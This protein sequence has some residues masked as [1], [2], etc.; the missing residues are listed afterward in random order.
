MAGNG[1]TPTEKGAHLRGR[2]TSNTKP[3]VDLRRAVH[4]LGLRFRLHQRVVG[5]CTPDFVLPRWRL[6][7]FVDG[8]FW[9]GCPKHSPAEFR[10]PNAEKWRE[11]IDTNRVRDLRNNSLLE[12]AGWRVL[13]V[14]ECEVKRSPTEA[15]RRVE[16]AARA[17]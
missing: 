12:E 3:E 1:W 15:A 9:H 14:W 4:A 17:Q 16:A 11:K 10:G 6:A 2:R 7:V 8:C 13:R 5:R